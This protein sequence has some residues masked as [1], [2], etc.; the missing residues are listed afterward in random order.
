MRASSQNVSLSAFSNWLSERAMAASCVSVPRSAPVTQSDLKKP[1]KEITLV[2]AAKPPDPPATCAFCGQSGHAIVSCKKFLEKTAGHRS[3]W[4]MQNRRCLVCFAVGHLGRDCQ[5]R[6]VC[7]VDGCEAYHHKLLLRTDGKSQSQ[8]AKDAGSTELETVAVHAPSLPVG[9]VLL[10]VIPVEVR[11][12]AGVITVRALLDEGSTVSLVDA[13]LAARLDV[14]GR[15]DPLSLRWTNSIEQRDER[16][17]RVSLEIRGVHGADWHQ[18]ENVR[19][20][21]NLSLPVQSVNLKRVVKSW[22]HLQDIKFPHH[23]SEAPL[24]L[25]GQDQYLLT[26]P[27]QVCE[28]PRNAPVATR[29][30]RGWVLHG[31]LSLPQFRSQVDDFVFSTWVDSDNDALHQLVKDSFTTENFGVKLCGSKVK[32]KAVL[33]AETLMKNTTVRVGER[34]ETGLLW[35]SDTPRL[36]DSYGM[37][38]RRLK[39]IER[40]MDQHPDFAKQYSQKIEDYVNKGYARQLSPADC[41]GQSELCTWYLPHFGVTNINKPGKLRFAFDAAANVDSVSLNSALLPGPD[42]LNPLVGVLM[43]FR[44]FLIAFGGDVMKMFH[45]VKIRAADQPA[46]RFL[47][48]GSRRT[49]A[50][51]IYAMQVMIFGAVSSPASA[52]YVMRCNADEFRE[53]YPEV[54]EAVNK[55]YYIDDYFDNVSSVPEAITRVTDMIEVQRQGG[56]R[57]RNW[58]SSSHDVLRSIP[59]DLRAMGDVTFDAATEHGSEMEP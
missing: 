33:R 26:V 16:S 6:R 38:F 23:S 52:Q 12:P 53:T 55:K 56:F 48:R 14:Q 21:K 57:I 20:R 27:R 47:W 3:R 13:D 9:S 31:N 11:G 49:G 1:K 46:Q 40:K 17:Q 8:P 24:L 15:V 42:L 32:S 7:G 45:Q 39:Q 10:R 50:P 19:T 37:A 34:F 25:L 59:A 18:L 28:G 51:D 35:K 5:K 22:P 2:A 29:T 54:A 36:P 44:Q 30:E 4:I 43:K 41:A 58:V